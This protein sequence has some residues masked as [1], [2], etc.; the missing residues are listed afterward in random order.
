METREWISTTLYRLRRHRRMMVIHPARYHHGEDAPGAKNKT[1]NVE[2]NNCFRSYL[3]DQ[4]PV[5]GISVEIREKVRGMEIR[6]S[7]C[8]YRSVYQ[9]LYLK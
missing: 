6:Y 2:W 5:V 3:A 4:G 1:W 9:P 8:L 7:A